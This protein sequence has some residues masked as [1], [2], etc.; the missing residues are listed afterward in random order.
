MDAAEVTRRLDNAGIANARANTMLDV[1]NH[2]QL[3]ARN[4]WVDIESPVGKV[5]ALIPPGVPAEFEPAMGPVPRLGQHNAAILAELNA[6]AAHEHQ[7][8]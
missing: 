1:W 6:A 8:K 5:P 3:R 7:S 2:P 4:R